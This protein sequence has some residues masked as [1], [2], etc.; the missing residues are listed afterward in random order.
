MSRVSVDIIRIVLL[1][2]AVDNTFENTMKAVQLTRYGG[3]DAFEVV[4]VP[5]PKSVGDE[6]LVRIHAAGINF[7]ETL[8][9]QNHYPATPTLPAILGVEAAGVIEGLGDRANEDLI[10]AR[11]AIPLFAAGRAGGYAEY[12]AISGPMLSRYRMKFPLS[13][14]RHC[15]F[16]AYLLL[17]FC[18]KAR[19]KVSRS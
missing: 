1:I 17:I 3:P 8:V 15:L 18:D 2:V 16:K 6:V 12:V 9:R 10:G 13:K 7:F 19:L 4:E 14:Q 11:V 5:T